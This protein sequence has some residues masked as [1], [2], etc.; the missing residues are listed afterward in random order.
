[1]FFKKNKKTV[2]M[3][4][5]LS[6]HV[7]TLVWFMWMCGRDTGAE[8]VARQI[9]ACCLVCLHSAVTVW[10]DVRSQSVLTP[11]TTLKTHLYF[12]LSILFSRTLSIHRGY[13][14]VSLFKE[15]VTYERWLRVASSQICIFTFLLKSVFIM[16]LKIIRGELFADKVSINKHVS[17][18]PL[19]R[20]DRWPLL[21][22]KCHSTWIKWGRM[23][24]HH[25]KGHWF[26]VAKR[27][28]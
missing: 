15:F 3:T 2:K 23:F 27:K 20:F 13:R 22:S 19:F 18:Q 14:N 4:I 24:V 16:K 25:L 21:H 7:F 8:Q 26:I 17:P 6:M 10:C 11:K 28:M 12:L 1:M 5:F 9:G